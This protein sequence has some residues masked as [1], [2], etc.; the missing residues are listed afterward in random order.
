VTESPP[1]DRQH[2]AR[3]SPWSTQRYTGA[4]GLGLVA[5]V[6]GDTGAPT[7]IFLHGGGQTRHSWAGSMRELIAQGYRVL[8]LDARGHGDS[9]WA[10][11][12]DYTSKALTADLACVIDTLNSPPALVGASMGAAT[13]LLFAGSASANAAAL[14]LVD[15]VPRFDPDGAARIRT[16]MRA[17]PQGFASVD[18]AAAAV[19]AYNPHRPASRD[20][21]G[22]MKNLRE[23]DGRLYWHWDPRV[24]SNDGSEHVSFGEKLNQA[25]RRVRIPTLLVRG[26][27][28]ELVTD[29]G[30]EDFKTHLQHLEV[31]DVAEA[32]HMV[33]GDKNEVFNSGILY[34]L[35]R[36][37][38]TAR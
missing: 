15:L 33:V 38:P 9:D 16:F 36:H 23:R 22:L 28:S 19:A 37:L 13:A 30:I 6:G 35:R 24:L 2:R 21:A 18:E 25:A 11:D 26:L 20:A 3:T 17:N 14:I 31:F 12:G 7:V 10:A 34:F 27:R 4:H 8:N 1:K 5:D 32:G 29:A